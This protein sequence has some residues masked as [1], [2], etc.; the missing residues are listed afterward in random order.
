MSTL[1][2]WDVNLGITTWDLLVSFNAQMI[3]ENPLVSLLNT[4][5]D[6]NQSSSSSLMHCTQDVLP[7]PKKNEDTQRRLS[8]VG[9]ACPILP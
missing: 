9:T 8:L 3:P 2:A 4:G 7:F 5:L 6:I 1:K